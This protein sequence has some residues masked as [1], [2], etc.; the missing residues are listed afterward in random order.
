[1]PLETKLFPAILILLGVHGLAGLCSGQERT[2]TEEKRPVTVA[3]AIRM[4]R[5]AGSGYP[6]WRKKSG[7]A[8]FSPDGKHFAIVIARGNIEK[9][10]NEYSLLVFRTAE[11][12]HGGV[13]RTLVS[14]SSSSNREGIVGL[15]W[16]KDNNAIFFLGTSADEPAQLYSVDSSSG[17][18]KKLTSNRTSL[19]SYALSEDTDTMVFAAER[20]ETDVVNEDVLR[21]GFHATTE[22]LPEL[23]RGQISNHE[24]ELFAKANGPSPSKPLQTLGPFDI[25]VNDLFLPGRAVPRGED[26]Y[27]RRT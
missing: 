10:T 12:S 1:M 17:E 2:A 19:V 20:P 21:H 6:S 9:N 7:F 18:L 27:D 23:I 15:K 26:R 25:G 4:T 5:V 3:D 8:V 13:P 22:Y 11:V 14:F 16:S 24:P